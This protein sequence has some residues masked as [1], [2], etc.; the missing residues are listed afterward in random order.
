MHELLLHK[1]AVSAY[2]TSTHFHL[3]PQKI[4]VFKFSNGSLLS[5]TKATNTCPLSFL[6]EFCYCTRS[7]NEWDFIELKML[8]LTCHLHTLNHSS[9]DQVSTT[10][11][12]IKMPNAWVTEQSWKQHHTTHGITISSYG[13]CSNF[14]PSHSSL[15]GRAL[16]Q[17]KKKASSSSAESNSHPASA[18]K[19][20]S[21][22]TANASTTD[23]W[24]CT[25][26]CSCQQKLLL[27]EQYL[28]KLLVDS[29]TQCFGQTALTTISYAFC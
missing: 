1:K 25:S 15:L 11:L 26:Q 10:H 14:I 20:E 19:A 3:H 12:W 29:V 18:T 9:V 8:L 4:Q 5:D 24:S 2:A 13:C 22:Y 17:P 27:L 6:K 23:V 16:T 28:F 21:S 7:R